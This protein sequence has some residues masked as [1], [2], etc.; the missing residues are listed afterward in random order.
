MHT[1]LVVDD[2][3][4]MLRV[5]EIGLGSEFNVLKAA[6]GKEALGILAEAPVDLVLADLKMPDLD[7]LELLGRIRAE[8]PFIPYIIM[9]A[10]GTVETAVEAMKKGAYD[11]VLKPIRMEELRLILRNA[12]SHYDLQRQVE[13]LK[14]ELKA[15]DAFSQLI[16]ANRELQKT[17]EL[18]RSIAHS[19]I[20]VLIHGESGTGKELLA[21][22][23]HEASGRAQ[24]P[25][26]ALN[27]AAIPAPLM[28]S[29]L[30][31][32][33]KG[34]F[35]GAHSSMPGKLELAHRGSLFL[36]EVGELAK[37][38]Q[39]K[40]LRAL[41]QQRFMRLGGS[42]YTSVDIRLISATNKDLRL[43][44]SMGD[45]RDDLYYRING[46]T[47][48]IPPLR[49]RREDIP[50]LARYF[51][52]KHSDEV[53]GK[54]KGVSQGFLEKLLGYSWPGNVRELENVVSSAMHLSEGPELQA[55]D[56]PP[57]MLER[58]EEDVRGSVP[59][60][61]E[62]LLE[63]KKQAREEASEGL[64]RSFIQAALA[65]SQG[66]VSRAAR[67]AGMNRRQFQGLM[68]KHRLRAEDFK[69]PLNNH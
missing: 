13:H 64:E 53:G 63:A 38:I 44:L 26:I 1:I 16:T 33:Q 60:T 56:I 9:T 11:Y 68:K 36:D 22:A 52:H 14:E 31:G 8:H 37:E 46:I 62:Q 7:G 58:G 17:L 24:Q 39:P 67:S 57:H 27:C 25:F 54:I 15:K 47:L 65:R 32:H 66:V 49:E 20:P 43:S 30:F 3:E 61:K 59:A 45:F 10:Y 29:E 40:L 18:A 6:G 35:T 51:I 12:L 2:E 28:E 23:I 50:L 42:G 4:K 5:L 69:K 48:F 41:E 34:A 19:R 55:G 21:R